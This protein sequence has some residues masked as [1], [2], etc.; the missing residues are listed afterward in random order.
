MAGCH[1]GA[2]QGTV[3]SSKAI[4]T[5]QFGLAISREAGSLW[6]LEA[7]AA[8]SLTISLPSPKIILRVEAGGVRGKQ[9][10]LHYRI[11]EEEV[12]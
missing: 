1:T 4:V 5:F 11:D 7:P 10:A 9:K 2:K 8:V 3:G 12:S 6:V